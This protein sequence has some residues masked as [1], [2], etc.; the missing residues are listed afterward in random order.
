[1]SP[2]DEHEI[3]IL[4]IVGV[5]EDLLKPHDEASGKR[6]AP[7]AAE[8][9]IRGRMLL[10]RGRHEGRGEILRELLPELDSLERCIRE[11]PDDATRAEGVRLALRGLWDIFRRHELE[12]IEGDGMPF[13][14]AIH[15][16][17]DTKATDRVPPGTVLNVV[18]VGYMLGKQLVRP[19]M[20]RVSVPVECP[21]SCVEEEGR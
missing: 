11:A 8:A 17:V 21:A 16:A 15:E 19:A 14:P 1:M 12:R 5:D 20:V 7:G 4:E 3:E 9:E 18:R 2:V 13:D 10:E 6:P